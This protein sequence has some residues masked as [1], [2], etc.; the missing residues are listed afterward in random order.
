MADSLPY[1]VSH[2]MAA[3]SGDSLT[4]MTMLKNHIFPIGYL[5][6]LST[7]GEEAA[8]FLPVIN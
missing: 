8:R 4:G 7:F 6:L 5:G 1:S 2:C 3:V